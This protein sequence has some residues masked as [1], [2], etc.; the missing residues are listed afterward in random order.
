MP[1]LPDLRQLKHRKP[2]KPIEQAYITTT[3]LLL[4][5]EVRSC[6]QTVNLAA[7]LPH[8]LIECG[9]VRSCTG[10]GCAHALSLLVGDLQG[11]GRSEVGSLLQASPKN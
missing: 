1:S 11:E 7:V 8:A 2:N 10:Q 9:S 3:N 4:S 6:L 5:S